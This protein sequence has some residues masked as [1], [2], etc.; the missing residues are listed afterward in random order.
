MYV[1]ITPGVLNIL[2]IPEYE[3]PPQQCAKDLRSVPKDQES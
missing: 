2:H 3:K 1:C